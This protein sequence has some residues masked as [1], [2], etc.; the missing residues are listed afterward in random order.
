MVTVCISCV[1]VMSSHYTNE[2]VMFL[3]GSSLTK[4]QLKGKQ[5]PVLNNKIQN[6]VAYNEKKLEQINWTIREARVSL[7]N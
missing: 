3:D 1:W 7:L 2:Y 5:A 4:Y 6:P